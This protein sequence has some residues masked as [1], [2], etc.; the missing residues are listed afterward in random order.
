LLFLVSFDQPL[1]LQAGESLDPKE[2]IE[3]VDLMLVAD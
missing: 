2:T 3:L 1:P